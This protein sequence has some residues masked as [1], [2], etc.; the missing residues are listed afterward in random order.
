MLRASWAHLVKGRTQDSIAQSLG[1]TPAKVNRLIAECREAGL[2]HYVIA[3]NAR[4]ALREENAL[5]Q[6]FGLADAW[7]VPQSE[8]ESGVVRSVGIAAG[9]YVMSSLEA[10]QTLA[11]G[12]GKTLD[13][14]VAGLQPRR[15]EGNRVVTLLGSM[16]RGNGLSSFDIASRYARILSAECCYLIAP[17]ITETIAESVQLRKSAHIREAIG[18]A[19]EA[20]IVLVDVDDL[21]NA[22]TLRLVGQFSDDDVAEL[23]RAGAVCILQGEAL[24]LEGNTISHPLADRTVG[25]ELDKFRR[26]P[27]R[28]VAAAGKRKVESLRAILQGGHC[29]IVITDEATAA[30]LL[31]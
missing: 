3:P 18:I 25:L 28:I 19:A 13:A 9:A 21:S 31:I 20:D 1:L 5:K 7:V 26:I 30:E 29:N 12:W 4:V 10:N 6:R 14:S 15:P 8:T 22:S 16:V 24:G 17:R 11:V 27:K 2:I 23:M